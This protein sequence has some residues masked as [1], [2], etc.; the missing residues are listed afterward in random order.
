MAIVRVDLSEEQG[1][2]PSSHG[3]S[4]TSIS[5]FPGDPVPSSDPHEAHTVHIDT[6]G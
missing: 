3:D 1:L 5:P 6:C 2:V 4:Q